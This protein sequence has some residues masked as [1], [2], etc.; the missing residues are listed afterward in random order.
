[1]ASSRRWPCILLV[2]DDP[3]TR[4]LYRAALRLSDFHV[5]EAGDGVDALRTIESCDVALIVLDLDLPRLRGRDVAAEVK[6]HAET[7]DIPIVVVTGTDASDLNRTDVSCVVY[8]PVYPE[9]LVSTVLR[10][11]GQRHSRRNTRISYATEG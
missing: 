7:R 5:L 4:E 9:V 11:L 6:A 2:D 3:D 10:C 1:M 8:K